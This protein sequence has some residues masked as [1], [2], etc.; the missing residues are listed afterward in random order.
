MD[1]IFLLDKPRGPSSRHAI[2][3]FAKLLPRKIRFG[4]A[5]TLDPLASGLLIL[6]IG[7]ATRLI[8]IYQ[9]LKKTYIANIRLG[10]RSDTDDAEGPITPVTDVVFPSTEKI[11]EELKRLTGNIEQT[12]PAFSAAKV[13]GKRAYDLARAGR[14]EL[15]KAKMVQIHEFELLNHSH[16]RLTIRWEVG[17]GTYIRSLARDLGE[18]LGC[19]GYLEDLRRTAI[20]PW[21]VET[22][23]SPEV[24]ERKGFIPMEETLSHLPVLRLS[25]PRC[26]VIVAGK[27]TRLMTE[28]CEK[29]PPEMQNQN[30]VLAAL[31]NS[32]E[33][34]LGVV[35]I[36]KPTDAEYW[37]VPWKFFFHVNEIGI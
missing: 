31:V 32:H 18:S 17:S 3:R 25:P 2:D 12:P 28:E 37:A 7:K 33:K 16:D 19:G 20:G 6:A 8:E 24:T 1:G 11:L 9:D 23:S 13:Q 4:H 36:R 10:G 14:P 34:M 21:D 26:R 22:A 30:S 15:P 29:L 27:K 5:G 35:E